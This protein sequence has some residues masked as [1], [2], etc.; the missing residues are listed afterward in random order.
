MLRTPLMLA[1]AAGALIMIQGTASAQTQCGGIWAAR[2]NLPKSVNRPRRA[3]AAGGK[4]LPGTRAAE[5]G[6][7]PAGERAEDATAVGA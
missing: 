6:S 4:A 1:T 2:C 3:K 7:P 5:A